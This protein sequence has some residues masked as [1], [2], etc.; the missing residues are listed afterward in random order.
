MKRLL[1]IGLLFLSGCMSTL[2]DWLNPKQG[3][4]PYVMDLCEIAEHAREKA[5][6]THL[7][8][9][10]KEAL[11]LHIECTEGLM[12]LWGRP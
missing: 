10:T 11:R 7:E 12:K 9:D 6:R 1:F 4:G 5:A 3:Y 8:G 2:E